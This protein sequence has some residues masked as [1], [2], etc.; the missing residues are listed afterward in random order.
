M[1]GKAKVW[2]S[3]AP[4]NRGQSSISQLPTS[5]SSNPSNHF[6]NTGMILAIPRS[7]EKSNMGQVFTSLW[8]PKLAH[9]CKRS[10]FPSLV[11]FLQRNSKRTRSTS[12]LV[13]IGRQQEVDK[14]AQIIILN[15]IWFCSQ[16]RLQY[17]SCQFIQPYAL[18]STNR[19]MSNKKKRQNAHKSALLLKR[20]ILK[21][22]LLIRLNS[23]G[24]SCVT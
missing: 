7:P 5:E 3:H 18:T 11:K 24:Q 9:G 21:S 10:Q 1:G 2:F 23:V 15:R 13:I 17:C 19:E 16:T 8:L 22:L 4:Q 14:P 20:N 12:P 6:K